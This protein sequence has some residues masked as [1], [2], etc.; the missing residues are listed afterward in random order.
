MYLLRRDHIKISHALFWIVFAAGGLIFG[1]FPKLSDDI[2]RVFGVSYGP[3]L[4]L[5]IA[6]VALVLRSIVADIQA[7]KIERDIR[8]LS[9]RIGIYENNY[10]EVADKIRK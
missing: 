4:I 5:V 8:V 3:M 7:T 1:L 9:Q 10:R 2:A 6:L